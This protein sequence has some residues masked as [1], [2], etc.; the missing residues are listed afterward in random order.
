MI[1]REK[2]TGAFLA[3]EYAGGSGGG[4]ALPWILCGILLLLA[5]SPQTFSSPIER[6]WV[7]DSIPRTV[8]IGASL[9]MTGSDSLW[10]NSRLLEPGIDYEFMPRRQAFVIENQSPVATDTLRLRYQPA[11]GWLQLTY[12]RQPPLDPSLGHDRDRV[13]KRPSHLP[14][15]ARSAANV[16]IT[17]AKSLRFSARS[18]GSSDFGQSLDIR[19]E[20][21]LATNLR[22]AGSVSDRGYDPSYGTAN[23][24]LNELDKI[25]LL[26]TSPSFVAQVGDISTPPALQMGSGRRVSGISGSVQRSR[27]SAQGLAARPKGRFTTVRFYGRDDLQ[28]P[29]QITTL[30]PSQAIVPGSETVWLDGQRLE[31]G[32]D[33]DYVIDYPTGRITF[34]VNSPVDSRSRIEIDYE[35]LATEYRREMFGGAAAVTLGD[36]LLTIETH[37]V[38]EGDDPDQRLTGELSEVDRDALRLAGDSMAHRS[39]IRPD[40]NGGYD[41]VADSLPDSV[42]HYVGEGA[43]EYSL[44]FSYVGRGEGAYQ[45]VGG[46]VYTWAGEGN[47]EYSPLV[48]LLPPERTDYYRISAGVSQGAIGELSLATEQAVHDRNLLS[49]IND[50]NNNGGLYDLQWRQDFRWNDG[51]N[52]WSYE[53]R[54]RDA[55][56]K[57]R[58]RLDRADFAYDY[59]LPDLVPSDCDE[60]LHRAGL[61]VTPIPGVTFR[62]SLS[63]LRYAG[64]YT[65]ARGAVQAEAKLTDRL[66]ISGIAGAVRTELQDT[67]RRPEGRIDFQE[68]GMQYTTPGVGSFG[69]RW[70]HDRR[71]HDYDGL[72]R[73]TRYHRLTALW[74]TAYESIRFEYHDEDSLRSAWR[75]LT[76]RQRLVVNSQ[77]RLGSMGYSATLSQRWLES[78]SGRESSFMGR[79]SYN[80]RLSAHRLDLSGTYLISNESRQARGLTYLEV[81]PGQGDYIL[82]DGQYI[83]D[84]HGNYMQVEEVL[85]DQARV[86]R[87]EKSFRL[88]KEWAWGR[89]DL[90]ADIEEELLDQ[91]NRVWWWAVPVY[92]DPEQPYLFYRRRYRAE[93]RLWPVE[94]W[95]VINYRIEQ[96]RHQRQVAVGSPESVNQVQRLT[97]RQG[98]GLWRLSQE[99]RLFEYSRDAYYSGSGKVD[100]YRLR[101]GVQHLS[102]WGE[103]G[104]GLVY[105]RAESALSQVS[106]LLAVELRH[107]LPL[108]G[109]GEVRASA[110][111][112]RQWLD[113]RSASVT[114]TLTDNHDGSRGV[115]WSLSWRWRVKSDWRISVSFNGRHTDDRSARIYGRSEVVAGF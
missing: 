65:G 37:W 33:N 86:R 5:L 58:R 52:G 42:F 54:R 45:Y 69:V 77:R 108:P 10:F 50:A 66:L 72:D 95:H 111:L 98:I 24:R 63:S 87:G 29:Y 8:H 115:N 105:R 28:G 82:V 62:P 59:F 19:I 74:R 34:A 81:D 53:F 23:S 99:A 64:W 6:M 97:L 93:A 101:A 46:N 39:G 15:A 38:R 25:N 104:A 32:A 68:A 21:M 49:P 114:Y 109:Q 14:P 56:Y 94:G 106:E 51:D 89:V 11:P 75:L 47:G 110:E 100:G 22:V 18:D 67:E 55:E 17:G 27:W 31:R 2:I 1:N 4:L 76:D 41:L 103:N 70:E 90:D 7:G 102:V 3:R 57:Q 113:D 35:P 26:L 43:G 88:R 60:S 79:L 30:G 92:S 85:S 12:G 20:G 13:D 112:Y 107:R 16:S 9:V 83:P 73:G 78:S 44:T 71:R 61:A 96:N 91:G 40:P 80:L 84:P 36:S 48:R